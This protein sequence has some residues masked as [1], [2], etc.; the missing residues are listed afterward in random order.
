[1]ISTKSFIYGIM[2]GMCLSYIKTNGFDFYPI[3]ILVCVMV[4]MMCN[5]FRRNE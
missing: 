5:K 3:A 1:M 2:F 4:I